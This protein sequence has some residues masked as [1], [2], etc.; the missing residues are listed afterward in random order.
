ML[1]NKISI[2]P[3]FLAADFSCLGQEIVAVEKAGAD[4]IHL[5]IMDGHFVPNL[6]IGPEMVR[7]LR[8]L[9]SLPFDIHLMIDPVDLFIEPFI[10]AGA[11]RLTFHVEVSDSSALLLKKIKSYGIKVGLSL[12]P[13]TPASALHPFLESLDMIL[14]MTVNPGFGGSTFIKAMLPKI[15]EIQKMVASLPQ[16]VDIA[17]DGGINSTT[18]PL[19]KA[20]GANIFIAG[21]SIFG[22]N[23]AEYKAR[24]K[25]LRE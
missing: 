18:A 17:V 21:S 3:S 11:D 1:N 7:N 24:I 23:P 4:G 6:S 16:K 10:K 8:P 20:H 25:A 19:A 15:S 2:F 9:T 12:K 5:D 22:G 13:E 14:V